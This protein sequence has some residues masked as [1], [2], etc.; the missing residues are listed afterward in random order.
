M[1]AE[2]LDT[3]VDELSNDAIMRMMLGNKKADQML[4]D[5]N[6]EKATGNTPM[7]SNEL[8]RL[9]LNQRPSDTRIRLCHG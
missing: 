6:T 1:A 8:L 4:M 9:G 3:T 5:I 2:Y 7:A